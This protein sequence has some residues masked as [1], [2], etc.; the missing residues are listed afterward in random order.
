MSRDEKEQ[1]GLV[2]L[3][4]KVRCSVSSG[5]A[6]AR[7]QRSL[8]PQRCFGEEGVP[9]SRLNQR[10]LL[11]VCTRGWRARS[12]S[13]LESSGLQTFRMARSSWQNNVFED[14]LAIYSHL[15][16]HITVCWVQLKM[17]KYLFVLGL[18]L[19]NLK[20][21]YLFQ[22]WRGMNLLPSHT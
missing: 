19:L 21:V 13:D 12:L 11:H 8:L 10:G 16:R 2:C 6:H 5:E 20:S 4:L 14:V 7:R 9:S 18:G 17:S 3:C 1:R 22:T 15:L